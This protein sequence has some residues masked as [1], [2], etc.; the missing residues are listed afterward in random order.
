MSVSEPT[1]AESRD[2]VLIVDDDPLARTVLADYLREC[3]YKVF[4]AAA[5][6]EALV[7]LEQ[8]NR[9]IDIVFSVAQIAGKTDG[10]GLARWVRSNRPDIDVV[11]VGNIEKAASS[12]ADLCEDGPTLAKP[13]HHPS[14]IALVNR[15]KLARQRHRSE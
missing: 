11:L 12:A 8:S 14:V 9:N 3:G 10:F 2:S 1:Q 15:L 13:Y 5:A 6:D 4:E 7:I